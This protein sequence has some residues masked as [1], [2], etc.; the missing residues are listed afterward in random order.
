MCLTLFGQRRIFGRLLFFLSILRLREITQEVAH[1][2][3]PLVPRHFH[4][5]H[6]IRQMSPPVP[7]HSVPFLACLGAL[8]TL[9]LSPPERVHLPYCLRSSSTRLYL[10]SALTWYLLEEQSVIIFIYSF[11][12]E[13]KYKRGIL[14]GCTQR[15]SPPLAY[16]FNWLIA[17]GYHSNVSSQACECYLFREEAPAGRSVYDHWVPSSPSDAQYVPCGNPNSAM[18]LSTISVLYPSSADDGTRYRPRLS[19]SHGFTKCS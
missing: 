19:S 11:V 9:P 7:S 13:S 18:L 8:A 10:S 6:L 17:Q 16:L 2:I 5:L 1:Y 12:S 14:G 4:R 15:R 3:L